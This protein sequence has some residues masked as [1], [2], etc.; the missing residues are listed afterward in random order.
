VTLPNPQPVPIIPEWLTP[1]LA[2]WGAFLSSV[3]LGW[4]LYRDLRDRSSLRIDVRVRRIV[5][6]GD[7]KWYAVNHN[8]PVQGASEQLFVIM[9]AV[10]IGRR[11]IVWEGW[12]GKYHKPVNGKTSFAIIPQHLPK[13]LEE[14]ESHSEMT[15]LGADLLP[16]CK[17][18]KRLFLWDT[19]G[20]NWK[21]SWWKLRALRKEALAASANS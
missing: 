14:G 12:G 4:N 3:A 2:I 9:S 1:L 17:N 21:L 7:G 10:N 16:A 15:S 5:Q 19:T 13:K 6:S 8:L 11:P 20:K 18:V